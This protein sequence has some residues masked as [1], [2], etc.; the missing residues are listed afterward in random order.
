M[1]IVKP[2]TENE[3]ANKYH[4]VDIMA[5]SS[6]NDQ[7]HG[8][9]TSDNDV[10]NKLSV[11]MRIILQHVQCERSFSLVSDVHVNYKHAA[12]CLLSLI[13]LQLNF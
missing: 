10:S 13:T 3:I 2:E 6:I 11:R 12:D 4:D 9:I 8:G 7:L 1:N 5:Q